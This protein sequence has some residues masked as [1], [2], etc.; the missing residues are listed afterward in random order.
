MPKLFV[1]KPTKLDYKKYFEGKKVTVMGLGILGRGVGDVKFLAENGADLIVT[2]LKKGDELKGSL[3]QL[4]NFGKIKFVLGGHRLEDFCGR[5]FILKSAGVPLDSP[6]IAEARKNKIPIEMSAALVAKF[7]PA[8]IVGITGTRGKTTTTRMVF[9]ILKD[10]GKKVHLGGNIHGLAN[11]PILDEAKAGDLIVMELD[12]WQL[13]GF[14][15]AKISP[16]VAAFTIF[17]EDHMNYYKGDVDKYFEDKAN[18]F[19]F[20]KKGDQLILGKGVESLV[21]SKY[22][23]K[24]KG[25]LTVADPANFSANFHLKIPGR[26]NL[27]NAAVAFEISRVLSIPEKQILKTLADFGGVEG[28]LELVKEI[29]GVKIFNDT[30]ATTP[31]AT[32]AGLQAVGSVTEGGG[33][34]ILIMGGA[35]KQL[36][37]SGLIEAVTSYCKSV[38][39]LPGTGTEKIKSSLELLKNADVVFVSSL[40]SAVS[41]AMSR[42]TSGDVILFSPAFASFGLFRNEY[43]R[44]DKFNEAVKKIV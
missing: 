1:M 44:G 40:E 30:A 4:K 7:S 24:L 34:T 36:D 22:G 33:K 42:A 23:K 17:L 39:V 20:Q 2:D 41:E 27:Y 25:K 13:Q 12:S 10:A 29:R 35:D 18:I 32:L 19:K 9:E 26:H 21:K 38:V 31:D 14:G 28:R 37:M 15:E 8:M 11:L 16:Q 43:D 6:F 3:D 5:D